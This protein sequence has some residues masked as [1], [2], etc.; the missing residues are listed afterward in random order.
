MIDRR[1]FAIPILVAALSL[2]T[3]GAAEAQRPPPEAPT[4]ADQVRSFFVEA[5]GGVAIPGGDLGD[6]GET[7]P[8]VG[9]AAGYRLN[10]RVTLRADI[11]T[12]RLTGI[13]ADDPDTNLIHYTGGVAYDIVDPT[14]RPLS[15]T[16][17]LGAGATTVDSDPVGEPTVTEPVELGSTSFSAVGAVRAAYDLSTR[18]TFF[19]SAGARY[20]GVDEAETRRLAN[21]LSGVESF[22]SAW[23]FPLAAGLKVGFE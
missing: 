1:H 4:L 10:E 2:G 18:I 21:A 16:A 17:R 13:R 12:N 15:L 6:F 19:G 7:G 14:T 3:G 23:T 22:G 11:S 5:E 8:S 20:F 9:L